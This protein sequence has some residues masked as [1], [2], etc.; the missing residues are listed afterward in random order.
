MQNDG[1]YVEIVDTGKG[2]CYA[3]RNDKTRNRFFPAL[4]MTGS[5]APL[6]SPSRGEGTIRHYL[7]STGGYDGM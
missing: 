5:R 3:L 4:R 7:P 1:V 6:P 2:D